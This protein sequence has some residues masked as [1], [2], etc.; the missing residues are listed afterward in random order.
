[1]IFLWVI[2]DGGLLKI[3]YS[4]FLVMDGIV[5]FIFLTLFFSL[6]NIVKEEEKEFIS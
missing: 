1:M 5:I 2:N 6:G 4:Y 3:S